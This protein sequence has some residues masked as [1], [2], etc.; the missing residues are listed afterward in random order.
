[1]SNLVHLMYCSTATRSM[2]NDDLLGLLKTARERNLE[3]DV[4]GMLLYE[5]GGFFQIIEGDVETIDKL[6]ALIESDARHH[7]LIKIIHEP[8][9]RRAFAD[10]TMGF[11]RLTA[12]EIADITG[13]N[14]FFAAGESLTRLDPGRAKKILH[15]FRDGRWRARID[16]DAE[17][18]L[19]HPW[20][21]FNSV[22]DTL[23]QLRYCFTPVIDIS[24]QRIFSQTASVIGHKDEAYLDVLK[25][26]HPTERPHFDSE[27]R[28]RAIAL[29]ASAGFD[30]NLTVN[31]VS[32][33]AG[34]SADVLRYTLG[35]AD[36]CGIDPSRI[37]L[38]LDLEHSTGNI[39]HLAQVIGQYRGAGMRS[40]LGQFVTSRGMLELF[41]S[42][43]PDLV[44]LNTVLLRNIV[45]D[46]SRQ[47]LVRAIVQACVD[48]GIEVV[49]AQVS[50]YKDFDWLRGEG[51]KLFHGDLFAGPTIGALGNEFS[52]P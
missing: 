29:A 22:G 7:E 51:I 25:Q 33:Q 1:M 36:Q 37:I 12:S 35:T 27:C 43:P 28:N 44:S 5:N 40:Q 15:A 32:G 49:A 3:H 52:L 10:W 18:D 24:A 42:S 4:T 34:D 47:A 26:I 16:K 20:S 48:L 6:Y 30:C 14:D 41:E 9:A 2:S 19:Q 50:R 38:E 13:A 23:D 17:D 8:I 11:S 39:E 46:G 45:E 21:A 31:F